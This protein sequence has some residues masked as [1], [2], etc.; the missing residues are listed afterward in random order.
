MLFLML[1]SFDQTIDIQF[2]HVN[3]F[4]VYLNTGMIYFAFYT[5]CSFSIM[6]HLNMQ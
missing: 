2:F 1:T 4:S 5:G 6:E 3:L